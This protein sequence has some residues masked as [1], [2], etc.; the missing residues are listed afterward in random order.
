MWAIYTV[1]RILLMLHKHGIGSHGSMVVVL[2]GRLLLLQVHK[3]VLVLRLEDHAET[4]PSQA[5]HR[6]KVLQRGAAGHFQNQPYDLVHF[7]FVLVQ[8][9]SFWYKFCLCEFDKSSAIKVKNAI[10]VN[11]LFDYNLF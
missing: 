10:K 9:I 2:V 4:A 3:V 5:L 11:L 6:L 8:N 7:I 1:G